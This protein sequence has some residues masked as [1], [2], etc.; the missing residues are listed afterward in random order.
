MPAPPYS[1]GNTVPISPSLPSS[2]TVASGKSPFS[3]HSMTCGLISR[4]ANSRTLF[5]NCSCSSFSWKSKV[6]SAHTG[7]VCSQVSAWKGDA[8]PEFLIKAQRPRG[9]KLRPEEKAEGRR[10]P[11]EHW[12]LVVFSAPNPPA[13]L[14]CI[15]LPFWQFPTPE[16]KPNKKT[17]KTDR[18]D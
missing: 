10:N 12:Q 8:E 9:K 18:R 5:F 16:A 4:S 1:W 13:G 6:A 7:I 2:L 14:F 11:H 3:S 15:F 17:Q